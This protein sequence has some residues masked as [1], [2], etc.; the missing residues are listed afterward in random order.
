MKNL[1]ICLLIISSQMNAQSEYVHLVSKMDGV[2]EL[3]NGNQTNIWGYGYWTQTPVINL[4]APLLIFNYE[5]SVEIEMTN[6]S[7]EAHTIHLH[8]LDVDQVNDGVPQTSF[9]VFQGE[10]ATYR[11]RANES[12]TYLYH[13]HVTTTLHL[14]MGM[15]G[16]LVV[17]REDNSLFEG[18]PTYDQSYYYLASDLEIET[19]NFPTQAYPFHEIQPDYFMING[20]S[21]SMLFDDNSQII[22]SN[23]SESV[24]LRLAN[25]AYAKTTFHFPEGSNAEVFM[26]DGRKIPSSIEI[27]SL[28][29]Y[30]GERYT[31]MLELEPGLSDY[32]QVDYFSMENNQFQSSNYIGINA[33]SYPTSTL[34]IES[35]NAVNIYPNPSN[36]LL[37]IEGDDIFAIEVFI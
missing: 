14:T 3:E 9:Q 25:I 26:S 23:S 27:D 7:P 11:F 22:Q 15:Y 30:P 12:G 33:Y 6:D 37:W 17:E 10:S 35:N 13:C 19:N 21:G 8:G 29:I 32:I 36:S 28:E 31:V 34:D 2:H 4:P 1:L 5:D 18:G 16:M 20:L 24:A